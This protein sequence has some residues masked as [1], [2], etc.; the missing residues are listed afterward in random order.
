VDLTSLVRGNGTYNIVVLTFNGDPLSF[1]SRE[2]IL[3]YRPQLVV[4]VPG[5]FNSAPPG[6]TQEF[7]NTDP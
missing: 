2:A 4:E 7:D 1:A 6:A 3:P 5:R